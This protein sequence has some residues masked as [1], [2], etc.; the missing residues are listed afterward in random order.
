MIADGSI[1]FVVRGEEKAS[2]HV[3]ETIYIPK[4]TA[5]S[6]KIRSKIAKAYVFASGGG[7]VDLLR[8]AG[9][10]Y[11]QSILPEKPE[12]WEKTDLESLQ[13]KIGF[14]LL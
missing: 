8:K 5:F 3:G 13:T 14:Q 10:Q 7:I 6:I 9:K 12:S 1:E 2:L 4:D 11:S